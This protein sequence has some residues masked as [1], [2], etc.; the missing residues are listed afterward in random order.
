MA[1]DLWEVLTLESRPVAGRTP[2]LLPCQ[3]SVDPLA[4]TYLPGA[5][6]TFLRVGY[7]AMR[8]LMRAAGYHHAVAGRISY[9]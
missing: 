8:V 7:L 6:Y 9:W 1:K 5:V 3:H 2:D 4:V